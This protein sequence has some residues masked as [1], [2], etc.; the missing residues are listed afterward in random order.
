MQEELKSLGLSYNE[1]IVYISLLKL[2]ETPV[3]NI[4]QDLKRIHRQSVYNALE[5]LEERKM[6]IK[7]NKNGIQHFQVADPEVLLENAK[8]QEMIAKRL[9]DSIKKQLK[10]KK[11]EHEIMVF[12]GEAQVRSSLMNNLKRMDKGATYYIISGSTQGFVDTIGKDF[13]VNKFEKVRS[14][15]NISSKLVTGKNAMKEMIDFAKI[16]DTKTRSDRYLP[17]EILNPTTTVIWNDRVAFHSYVPG[18]QFVIEVKNNI[19][20]ESYLEHFNSLWEIAKK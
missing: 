6:V 19:L 15:R 11:M 2:G 17:W 3:G 10:K 9:S 13:F 18:N 14:Q 1:Q 5:A 4:I 12:E 8:K 20:R 7:K 16:A